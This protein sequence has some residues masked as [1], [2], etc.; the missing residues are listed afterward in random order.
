M[1]DLLVIDASVAAK[2]VLPEPG[3][4]A[5]TRLMERYAAGEITLLAPDLLMAECA[6]LLAKRNRRKQLSVE[7]A[8]D[9]FRLLRKFAPRLVEM[10]LRLSQALELSLRDR[11]SLWDCVY[12]AVATEYRCPFVTADR[13]LFEG[14]KERFPFV[15]FLDGETPSAVSRP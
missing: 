12:L 5:A 2:W 14:V 11:L 1:A 8:R 3:R 4:A 13:R 7:Q 9:A 15:Q 6:S 10:R